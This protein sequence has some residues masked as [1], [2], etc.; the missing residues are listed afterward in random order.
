M[1][2]IDAT[3]I[4]LLLKATDPKM[5]FGVCATNLKSS[6]DC[7]D[8]SHSVFLIKKG[9]LRGFGHVMHQDYSVG[10]G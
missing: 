9:G 3:D 4:P 8:W 6:E 10:G 1:C 7:W 5:T 2:C